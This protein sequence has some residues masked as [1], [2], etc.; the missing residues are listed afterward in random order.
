MNPHYHVLRPG[1]SE[2]TVQPQ[3]LLGQIERGVQVD[4]VYT[5]R[6]LFSELALCENPQAA[7]LK[8]YPI[9]SGMKLEKGSL[10]GRDPGAEE[11]RCG[12]FRLVAE[13][14]KQSD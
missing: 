12:R 5:V 13:L 9:K 4:G 14:T 7:V 10:N 3:V 1:M 2:D 8:H 11:N 6:D